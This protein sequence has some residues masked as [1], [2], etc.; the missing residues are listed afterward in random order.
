MDST[1]VVEM[2]AEVVSGAAA[3]PREDGEAGTPDRECNSE[4]IST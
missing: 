4:A 2:D 3:A 1:E